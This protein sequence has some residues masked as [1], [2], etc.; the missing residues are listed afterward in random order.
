ML[1]SA[2]TAVH[3]MPP[4]LLA[5]VRPPVD[6]IR[7]SSSPFNC[8]VPPLAVPSPIAAVLR[9]CNRPEL[10]KLIEPCRSISAAVMYAWAPT[11]RTLLDETVTLLVSDSKNTF[12]A[13][14]T[15]MEL[16]RLTPE[17]DLSVVSEALVKPDV[18]VIVTVAAASIVTEDWLET[19]DAE[20]TFTLPELRVD[21]SSGG[22]VTVAAACTLIEWNAEL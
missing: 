19:T 8:I 7:C 4:E 2:V 22:K 18:V 13:E 16:K 21:L 9:T 17:P 6:V 20:S 10:V 1:L 11:V 3:V 5:T 14:P 12:P 15:V